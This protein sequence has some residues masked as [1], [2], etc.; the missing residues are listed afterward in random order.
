MLSSCGEDFEVKGSADALLGWFTQSSEV[1]DSF[2]DTSPGA[3]GRNRSEL[4][5][6]VRFP[7]KLKSGKRVRPGVSMPEVGSRLRSP[8]V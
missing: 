4:G 5:W 3:C 7:V 6:P 2:A 1:I 8:I